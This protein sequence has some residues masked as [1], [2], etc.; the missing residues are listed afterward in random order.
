MSITR[1]QF[2]KASATAGLAAG[3]LPVLGGCGATG[4]GAPVTL[5]TGGTIYVDAATTAR[6]LVVQGGT[7]VALDVD[8]SAWPGA[9][10]V[11][12]GGAVAYPGFT[13]SHMHL[14]ETGTMLVVGGEIRPA[15]RNG[16][17]VAAG[18]VALAEKHPGAKAL[19]AFG[20]NPPDYDAWS[21]DDLAEIDAVEP[22]RVAIVFDRLGHNCV[23]NGFAMRKFD[24]DRK[25]VPYGGTV[26]RQ[27]GKATGMFREAAMNLVATD[28]FAEF[29]DASVKAGTAALAAQWARR[30]YT[31]LVDLMGATGLQLMRPRLL[32][33]LEQEGKLPL[34]VHYCHTLLSLADVE[35]AAG[36]VGQDTD[37]VRFV[38]GKIF[39]DGA[40]AGGQAWTSWPHT[41]PAGSH[42]LPQITTDDA[43]APELNL[44]RI[45]ARAEELGLDMHYHAQGDLAIKA[46]LDAL[47]R[48]LDSTG[49][50]RGIHTLIHLAYPT[51]ELVDHLLSVNARAGGRHVVAT[52]Q[53]GFWEV[54]ADT[55]QYY[56]DRALD[57]YPLKSLIDSGV[58]VGI[59]TDFAVSPIELVNP[60]KIMGVAATGGSYAA[61]HPPVTV[62]DVVQGLTVGSARTTGQRDVGMLH[63]GYKADMVVYEEDLYGIAPEA[64]SATYPALV[65]TWVGGR[66]TPP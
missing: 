20:V 12:L 8:P 41:L 39:V 25:P 31:G 44:N 38:G 3:V 58:S 57:A 26:V 63:V 52:T 7:V 36:F 21:L 6:N 40:F 47:A 51:P 59:S 4:D 37:L 54:E 5:F 53:P 42:G 10:V 24:A 17:E 30:G 27:D 66:L 60:T 9:A 16:R 35:V 61:H 32:R 15:P 56:G 55:T 29:D 1:R 2:L 45:V 28:A 34:R 49:R 11:D 23:V 43:H 65:S 62:Q 19:L 18:L 13:D 50:L 48:V 14:M 33:E 22:G 46:V 64:L